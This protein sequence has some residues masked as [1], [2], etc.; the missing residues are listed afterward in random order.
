MRAVFEDSL[1]L[2][3]WAAALRTVLIMVFWYVT[4]WRARVRWLIRHVPV[5]ILVGRQV[6]RSV[7]VCRCESRLAALLM[8]LHCVQNVMCSMATTRGHAPERSRIQ[9]VETSRVLILYSS[10]CSMIWN[11][12]FL[13]RTRQHLDLDLLL[14]RNGRTHEIVKRILLLFVQFTRKDV[15]LVDRAPLFGPFSGVAT[16][17]NGSV[18]ICGHVST[19]YPNVAVWSIVFIS[20]NEVS[21]VLNQTLSD[22]RNHLLVT[23]VIGH[24]QLTLWVV[25]IAHGV[26]AKW[27]RGLSWSLYLIHFIYSSAI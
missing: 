22:G 3:T 17:Q 23:A 2:N 7:L 4:A 1:C 15:D 25:V 11:V 5:R 20:K 18:I 9:R 13:L 21:C 10:F 26:H 16:T 12:G 6:R 14:H 19:S 8:V 27:W 24:L